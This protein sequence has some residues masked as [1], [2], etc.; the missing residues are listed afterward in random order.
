MG[1]NIYKANWNIKNPNYLSGVPQGFKDCNY[2]FY[3]F[4]MT[5]NR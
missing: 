4:Y 3:V 2:E 5:L 1:L